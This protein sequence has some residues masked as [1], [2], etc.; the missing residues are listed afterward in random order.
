MGESVNRRGTTALAILC[1]GLLVALNVT[2]LVLLAF[3]L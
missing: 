1:A 2:L 3:G